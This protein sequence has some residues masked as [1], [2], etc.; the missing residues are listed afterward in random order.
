LTT[1]LL[2]SKKRGKIFS[3]NQTHQYLLQI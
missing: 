2:Q 1:S 3:F